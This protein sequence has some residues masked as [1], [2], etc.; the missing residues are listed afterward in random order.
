MIRQWSTTKLKPSEEL[1]QAYYDSTGIG[2]QMLYGLAT[3]SSV[4][5]LAAFGLGGA[6]AAW[7]KL[8]A[9]AARGGVTGVAARTGQVAVPVWQEGQ[10]T[11]QGGLT[12][13]VSIFSTHT[14]SGHTQL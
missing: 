7:P 10:Q 11:V 4:A 2:S 6:K 1:K 12:D 9:A 13:W 5:I 8:E 3:P 14:H